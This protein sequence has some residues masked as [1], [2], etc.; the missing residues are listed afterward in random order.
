M[1]T[2]NCDNNSVNNDLTVNVRTQR[3]PRF[4]AGSELSGKVNR[5]DVEVNEDYTGE[6]ENFELKIQIQGKI[7]KADAG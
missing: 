4:K 6:C 3:C 1:E 5:I 7:T 2:T